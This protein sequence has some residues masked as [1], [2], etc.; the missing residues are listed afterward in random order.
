MEKEVSVNKPLTMGEFLSYMEAFEER[1]RGKRTNLITRQDI[2][3]EIGLTGYCNGV[4]KGYLTPI[5][6]GARNSKVR[7][8]RREYKAY[9]EY[10]KR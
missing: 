8:D 2:I 6:N 10:L 1:L 3:K 5:K 7:I 4:E 9:L